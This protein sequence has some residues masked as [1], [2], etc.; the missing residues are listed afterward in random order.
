MAYTSDSNEVLHV[1]QNLV[2]PAADR[3][4]ASSGAQSRPLAAS[5]LSKTRTSSKIPRCRL[6]RGNTQ[7]WGGPRLPARGRPRCFGPA[8]GP[9]P[10]GTEG[11]LPG[12]EGEAGRHPEEF[13]LSFFSRAE[14]Y[15][16]CYVLLRE[17]GGSR[18]PGHE[19]R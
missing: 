9:A 6:P 2:L 19:T 10:P 14:K 15:L 17:S 7:P 18:S 12:R 8:A 1:P 4:A 16:K 5:L 11:P 13:C 3:L